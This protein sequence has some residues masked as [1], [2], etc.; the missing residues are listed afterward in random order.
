MSLRLLFAILLLA[1][2]QA[3]DE[4]PLAEKAAALPPEIETVASGGFWSRDGHHGSY[5]L[6]IEF[7]RMG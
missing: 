4:A 3:Q 5:R 2:A 1:A 7:S 6:V